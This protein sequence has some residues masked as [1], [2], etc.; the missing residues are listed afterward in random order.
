[1]GIY[2]TLSFSLNDYILAFDDIDMTCTYKHTHSC[3]ILCTVIE[4]PCCLISMVLLIT[5]AIMLSVATGESRERVVPS[6]RGLM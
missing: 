2:G 6:T 5:P 1:M 4:G 3:D